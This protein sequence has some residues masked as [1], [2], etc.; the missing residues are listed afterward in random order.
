MTRLLSLTLFSLTLAGLSL[1]TAVAQDDPG[2]LLEGDLLEEKKPAEKPVLDDPDAKLLKEVETART[3]L[4]KRLNPL[5]EKVTPFPKIDA[6]LQKIMGNWLKAIDGYVEPHAKALDA[7]RTAIKDNLPPVKEKQAKIIAKA[8]NGFLKQ[9][10]KISKNV[11]K[12]E[13]TLEKAIAKS[14]QE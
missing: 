6:K 5:Q 12:L 3:T 13:K 2:G 8:R 4:E 10:K 1:G 14:E 11:D 7:Y 9:I